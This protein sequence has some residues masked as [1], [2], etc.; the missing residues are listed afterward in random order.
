LTRR[1]EHVEGDESQPPGRGS[2]AIEDR[3]SDRGEILSRLAV[4]LADGD[5]LAVKRGSRRNVCEGCEQRP[6]PGGEIR[7]TARPRTHLAA[8]ADMEK[9]S[10]AVLI[11]PPRVSM[12]ARVRASPLDRQVSVVADR[13]MDL[14]IRAQ[15]GTT[16]KASGSPPHDGALNALD[17]AGRPVQ[18][19]R[20][21]SST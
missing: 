17:D 19:V 3:A 13:T 12:S 4:A 11:C 10:K 14:Q 15:N 1:Q 18:T 6:E 2:V 20:A 21:P 16:L 5:Q 7:A 9:E 8:V